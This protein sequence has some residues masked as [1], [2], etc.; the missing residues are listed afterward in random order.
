MGFLHL[1]IKN[2]E[3]AEQL[4]EVCVFEVSYF[5]VFKISFQLEF[6]SQRMLYHPNNDV[7][8][9]INQKTSI[10]GI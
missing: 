1:V 10:F 7:C 3:V 4:A 8:F 6:F 5:R 9:G 2:L